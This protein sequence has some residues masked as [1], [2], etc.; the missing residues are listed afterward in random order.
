MMT[1]FRPKTSHPSSSASAFLKFLL[2]QQMGISAFKS[3]S[4]KFSKEGP[5]NHI[6]ILRS[7]HG[8][9]DETMIAAEDGGMQRHLQVT[10]QLDLTAEHI[11]AR[12]GSTN[13]DLE[14]PAS[15]EVKLPTVHVGPVGMLVC[16]PETVEQGSSDMRDLQVEM[17]AQYPQMIAQYPQMHASVDGELAE[18]QLVPFV[19]KSP[20]WD[21]FE[22]LEMV[23]FATVV[24]K[25]SELQLGDPRT[26]FNNY[27]ETLADLKSYGFDVEAVV[28][29]INGLLS[30]KESQ[31]QLQSR[32]KEVEI[33]IAECTHDRTKLE[34]DIEDS[35]QEDTQTRRGARIGLVNEGEQRVRDY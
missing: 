10:S 2:Q 1:L 19:K 4:S 33:Q 34:E 28:Y 18:H 21:M 5:R 17:I 11:V 9:E 29:R 14:N 6:S 32:S 22:S 3:C 15:K 35:Q 8:I 26:V 7:N 20:V 23:L 16:Q 31:E 25:T 24:E 30:I 13:T 12:G 27:L